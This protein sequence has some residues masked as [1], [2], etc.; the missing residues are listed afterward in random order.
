MIQITNASN[1][2]KVLCQIQSEKIWVVDLQN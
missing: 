2:L 1:L